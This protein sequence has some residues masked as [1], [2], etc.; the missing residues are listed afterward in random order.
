MER[1]NLFSASISKNSAKKCIPM[2]REKK[3]NEK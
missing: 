1:T 3:E 2:I